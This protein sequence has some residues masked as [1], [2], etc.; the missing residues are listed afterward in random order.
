MVVPC[1]RRLAQLIPQVGPVLGVEPEGGLVEEE[2]LGAVHDPE[3]DLEAA[4]LPA[5][6]GA[7]DPVL[8]AGQVEEAG[9]LAGP[10]VGLAGAHP[11]EAALEEQVLATGGCE[12]GTPQL[13]HVAD[14]AAHLAGPLPHV[15]SRHHRLARILA[16]QRGEDAQ[17]GGLAGSV[18]SQ[19]TVDLSG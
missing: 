19:E 17:S 5:R 4:S 16:Q 8:E 1:S 7:H 9:E 2:H 15:D 3:R 6:T 13:T 12:V 14:D 11:V 10:M 18:G